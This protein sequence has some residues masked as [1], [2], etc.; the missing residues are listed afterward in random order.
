MCKEHKKGDKTV[1]LPNIVNTSYL[2][3]KFH[4]AREYK[5]M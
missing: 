4:I 2:W 3:A 5:K 1:F